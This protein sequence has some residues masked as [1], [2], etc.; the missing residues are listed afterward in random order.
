MRSTGSPVLQSNFGRHFQRLNVRP[1]YLI[2]QVETQPQISQIILRNLWMPT[3]SRR[4]E[5]LVFGQDPFLPDEEL[6]A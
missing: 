4:R 3:I 6:R 1:D 2:K 5:L